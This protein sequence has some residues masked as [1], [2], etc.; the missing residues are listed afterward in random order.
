MVKF[1]TNIFI[2]NGLTLVLRFTKWHSVE[3][4][5]DNT[6]KFGVRRSLIFTKNEIFK[7]SLFFVF[8]GRS[9]FS[10]SQFFGL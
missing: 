3:I 10:F 2:T 1:F 6:S 7:I 8:S 4:L 9:F 5:P